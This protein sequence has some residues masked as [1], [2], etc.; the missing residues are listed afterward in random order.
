MHPPRIL[1]QRLFVDSLSEPWLERL[2]KPRGQKFISVSG[3]KPL[4]VVTHKTE[5][6]KYVVF[7]DPKVICDLFFRN[8]GLL[9]HIVFMLLK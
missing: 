1:R 5:L 3:S 6:L 4:I 7:G 2:P 8:I 9:D